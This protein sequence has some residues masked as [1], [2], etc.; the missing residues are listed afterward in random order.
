MLRVFPNINYPIKPLICL[1][2]DLKEKKYVHY[3]LKKKNISNVAINFGSSI[4]ELRAQ[5]GH[6]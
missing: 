1:N 4:D 6:H 5:V 3:V 2:F